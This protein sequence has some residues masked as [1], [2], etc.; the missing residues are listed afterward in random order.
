MKVQL[1]KPAALRWVSYGAI[2]FG[3]VFLVAGAVLAWVSASFLADA[4][5]AGGTVV[6]LEWGHTD[7]RDYGSSSRRSRGSSSDVAYPRVQF[8]AADGTW[9]NFRSDSGSNPP[10]YE[11]GEEVEVVYRADSPDDARIDGFLSLWLLPL[12]FGGMG[13][14]FAGIGTAVAVKT[15]RRP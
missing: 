14:L 15:R 2:A 6:A 1:H 8:T 5:R 12:I 13:L 10:S 4:E 3:S 7:Y 11:V 9:R